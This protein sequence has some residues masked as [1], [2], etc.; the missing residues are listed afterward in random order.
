MT[1]AN[2]ICKQLGF[3]KGAKKGVLN[4]KYGSGRGQIL[5]D[6]LKCT[7]SESSIL[8]C[9]F[10]PWTKHDCSNNEWAGV[11]CKEENDDCNENEV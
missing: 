3:R 11:V 5:L 4:S 6:E 9:K 8:E 1:E 2:V 7:G 10:D